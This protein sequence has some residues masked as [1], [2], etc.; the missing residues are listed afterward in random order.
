MTL[1]RS[2]LTICANIK[3]ELIKRV[4][5]SCYFSLQLNENTN[6]VNNSH[7][8]CYV[9]YEYEMVILKDLLF[10]SSLIHTT[11]EEVFNKVNEFITSNGTDW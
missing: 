1:L 7:L 8:L 4:W 3:K 10:I 2:E 9:R 11:S 5:E 6:I